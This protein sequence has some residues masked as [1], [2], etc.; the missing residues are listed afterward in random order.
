MKIAEFREKKKKK[1]N[2]TETKETK[3]NSSGTEAGKKY[4]MKQNFKK[5][6]NTKPQ[7]IRKQKR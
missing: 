7:K 1:K 5:K 6:T 2:S 4:L 3:K